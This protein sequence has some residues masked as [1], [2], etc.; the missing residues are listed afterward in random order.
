MFILKAYNVC[1]QSERRILAGGP[2]QVLRT[3]DGHLTGLNATSAAK[4][5]RVRARQ[6]APSAF[7][8]THKTA[9]LDI[10]ALAAVPAS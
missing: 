1:N 10:E 9:S 6:T 8:S 4:L 2:D 7:S 5:S 3:L